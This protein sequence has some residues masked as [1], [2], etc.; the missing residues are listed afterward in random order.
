MFSILLIIQIIVSLS[1]ITLVMLQQGKGADMGAAFGSGASGTVFG[2]RGSGSFF[3]RATGILATV[4]FINCLLIASPLIRDRETAPESIAEQIE[5]QAA[6]RQ[7]AVEEEGVAT[8]PV[9]TETEARDLP[10]DI[11]ELDEPVPTGEVPEISGAPAR[12]EDLPE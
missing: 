7:Q 11:P 2:A 8:T 12:A 1:I 4:F 10:A 5:K 6:Q 3:T 9:T